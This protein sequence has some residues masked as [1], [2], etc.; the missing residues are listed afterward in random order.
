MVGYHG[1]KLQIFP[2]FYQFPNINSKNQ[3]KNMLIGNNRYKIPHIFLTHHH[4]KHVH[5]NKC[6]NARHYTLRSMEVFIKMI[7]KYAM[8]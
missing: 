3:T 5:T 8:E 1:V 4:V 2:P 7:N 6:D